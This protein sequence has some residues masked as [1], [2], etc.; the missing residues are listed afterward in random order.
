MQGLLF[1]TPWPDTRLLV[2]VKKWLET[3][4]NG[5]PFPGSAASAIR[6]VFKYL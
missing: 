5:T 3:D 6:T 4:K 2:S 1:S